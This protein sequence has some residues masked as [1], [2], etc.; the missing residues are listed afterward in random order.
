MVFWIIRTKSFLPSITYEI[1]T[2]HFCFC[3]C[4]FL[5]CELPPQFSVFNIGIRPWRH[6]RLFCSLG[7]FALNKLDPC[8]PQL[9]LKAV[10]L[11]SSS[12][13]LY[14]S[15]W[16]NM[17]WIVIWVT[18][19]V[20]WRPGPPPPERKLN[21]AQVAAVP[22]WPPTCVLTQ[23]L[24]WNN[25]QERTKCC[26]FLGPWLLTWKEWCLSN[27]F[28]QGTCKQDRV[29]CKGGW[30]GVKVDGCGWIPNTLKKQHPQDETLCPSQKC[31][32]N[33]QCGM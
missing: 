29:R 17:A 1:K 4:V 21:W 31:S 25:C 23:P 2:K 8:E 19:K 15:V 5:Y 20:R 12:E 13:K 18:R 22:S 28:G 10:G 32:A 27:R 14:L 16:K 33:A 30:L 9:L 26:F 6:L 3:V 7:I 11:F 24:T